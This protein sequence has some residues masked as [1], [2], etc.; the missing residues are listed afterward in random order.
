MS[1]TIAA[2]SGKTGRFAKLTTNEVAVG[3]AVAVGVVE[4]SYNLAKWSSTDNDPIKKS[5][6]GEKA[7]ASVIDTGIAIAAV[8]VPVLAALD[9][10]WMGL[11]ELFYL[12]H[13][14]AISHEIAK[15]PSSAIV[16]L[17]IYAWGT[18]VPTQVSIPAY[19]SVRDEL[20]AKLVEMND[21]GKPFVPVFIDPN[22]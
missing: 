7:F 3:L 21:F 4:T 18:I 9:V 16:F 17:S 12:W 6:Y 20:M 11:N 19:E 13:G 5:A 8:F 15:S 10:V 14:N 2:Y 1:K 22:L